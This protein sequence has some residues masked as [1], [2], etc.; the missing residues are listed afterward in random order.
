[1]VR[2]GASLEE[3]LANEAA[4]RVPEI[5]PYAAAMSAV[6]HSG[7]PSFVMGDFNTPS[8][9]DWTAAAVASGRVALAVDWPVSKIMVEGGFADSYRTVHPDPVAA[10]GLTWT[11]GTP[12]PNVRDIETIDRI[13]MIWSAGPAKPVRSDVVGEQSGPDV[14]I[15][16]EVWPADHRAVASTFDVTPAPA[17]LLVA[18]DQPVIRQGDLL[19]TR[20]LMPFVD[21]GR[22]L[23]ILDGT[24]DTILQSLPVYDGSDHR[25]VR[26]GTATFAPGA[27]RAALIDAEGTVE[28]SVPFWLLA[29]EAQPQIEV[30]GTPTY[31][32]GWQN[33]PANRL[34]WVGIYP[35]GETD[36]YN[37]ISF[38]Y[39][40]ARS[41]GSLAIDPK[42]LGL[43]PGKYEARLMLDDGYSILAQTEFEV[44]Q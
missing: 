19:T 3:I 43:A 41:T 40:G 1:M 6:A 9:A 10:P 5:E 12:P 38:D 15:G 22:K 35:A 13:D 36:L 39:T 23:A 7:V 42:E 34:D 31:T 26:F 37:Y 27:Y 21:A 8:H 32:A 4:T 18:I 17:P 25:A 24:S 14:G 11:S 44:A 16:L 33:G 29:R 28:A 2:D 20:Y 30:S